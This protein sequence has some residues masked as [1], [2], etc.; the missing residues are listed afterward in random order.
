MI[1]HCDFPC[2][3]VH[4][5]NHNAQSSPYRVLHQSQGDKQEINPESYSHVRTDGLFLVYRLEED[6]TLLQEGDGVSTEFYLGALLTRKITM[7]NHP[8]LG[9]TFASIPRGGFRF[10]FFQLTQDI[11]SNQLLRK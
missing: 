8:W 10:L 7:T 6:E 5:K 1:C 2:E 3:Q 9:E 4:R 11:H